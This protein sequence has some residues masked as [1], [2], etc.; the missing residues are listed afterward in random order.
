MAELYRLAESLLYTTYLASNA[1]DAMTYGEE[2]ETGGEMDGE[3]EREGEY[4]LPETTATVVVE[5]LSMLAV[6]IAA[7][8]LLTTA[9]FWASS[10]K[11]LPPALSSYE[12]EMEA[13]EALEDEDED[14]LVAQALA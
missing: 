6:S 9:V 8:L 14:D 5:Q 7:A 4:L 2:G 11:D 1:S 12:V 3:G 10:R 13:L